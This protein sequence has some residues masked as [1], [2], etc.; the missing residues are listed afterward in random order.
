MSER[1]SERARE[2]ESER[3]SESTLKVHAVGSVL[4]FEASCVRSN[5]TRNSSN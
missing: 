3:V 4:S 1:V 5:D 2:R